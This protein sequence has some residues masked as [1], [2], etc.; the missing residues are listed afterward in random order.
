[1]NI[2]VE[3]EDTCVIEDDKNWIVMWKHGETIT[4]KKIRGTVCQKYT[5]DLDPYYPLALLYKWGYK[6][7]DE[8]RIA[9]LEKQFDEEDDEDE[10]DDDVYREGEDE[11]DEE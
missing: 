3:N 2:I 8:K 1:M 6:T 7:V 9:E 4:D 11:D 5:K 10:D